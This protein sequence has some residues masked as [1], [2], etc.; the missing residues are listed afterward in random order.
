M[1]T[2]TQTTTQVY[3]VFIKAT[4]EAIWEAI[5]SP[6]FTAQYFY[7]ARV[8]ANA[9]RRIS[10]MG[11]ITGE[12]PVFE[13]DPPRRLVHGWHSEWDEDLAKEEPSRVTWDIV[14]QD[15]GYSLLTVTHDQLEGAPK[16][17]EAVSGGWMLVISGLKTLLETGKPMAGA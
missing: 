13:F 3:Q 5:T 16:T 12:D 11:D 15:G 9:T 17:A 2:M 14:P 6:D 1:T 7:G 10:K 4:P 8:E